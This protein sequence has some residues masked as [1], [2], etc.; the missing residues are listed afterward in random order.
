MKV[1]E[2][3]A[4]ISNGHLRGVVD[5]VFFC[6]KVL[7]FAP[8]LDI[9]SGSGIRARLIIEG[10]RHWGIEVTV[11]ARSVPTSLLENGVSFCKL[12]DA[13][14]WANSLYSAICIEHP[15][16]IYGITEALADIVL[17]TGNKAGLPVAFDLHGI[18]AI[19][20]FELGAGH[21][22]RWARL[23]DSLRWLAAVR[24]ANVVTVANPTLMPILRSFCHKVLPVF[25]ITNISHFSPNGPATLLGDDPKR[26][27]VLYAGNHYRWQGM[28]LLIEALRCLKGNVEQI[29]VL[30]LGSVG[31]NEQ[32]VVDW[33]SEFPKGV[34]EFRGSVDFMDVAD[35]YR[36]AD[37]LIIPR[38][39]LLSTYFALP[40]KLV[41]GM[42]SGRAIIATDIAPHR[43]A[44]QSPVAGILCPATGQGLAHCLKNINNKEL[45]HELGQNARM[46]AVSNF[47]HLLQT[48]N[49]VQCFQEVV[50]HRN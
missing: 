29:H 47:C 1:L 19:E 18:G 23:C 43:W 3:F 6:M 28:D 4:L 32:Q 10:L 36:G 5:Y 12:H 24:K 30:C 21:G 33:Q 49:I 25:G 50:G 9:N 35:Y 16:I 37:V 22:P 27:K 11:A 13:G 46:R 40:Q 2:S 26:I 7:I 8:S 41:D 45:L 34:L 31:R 17:A 14:D 15:D 44:L 20:V 42:A 38:P 39:F 48:H